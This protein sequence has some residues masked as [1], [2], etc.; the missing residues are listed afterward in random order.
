[1]LA[2]HSDINL[3]MNVYTALGVLDQAAAVEALPA[4]P[5]DNRGNEAED[6]RAT[7][8]EG[9]PGKNGCHQKVP[10]VVTSGAEN[11]AILPASS[12]L[13]IAPDCTEI[14]NREGSTSGPKEPRNPEENGASCTILHQY[15]SNCTD[16][17][18]RGE[19]NSHP[20][21]DWILS[22]ARLPIPPLARP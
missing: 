16:E 3:T 18:A 2:R 1:M 13:Q 15:E 20:F 14:A 12:P 9:P 4:I 7:G 8:T 5:S 22:P 17:C 19:S 10:T 21:R 6:L 11:G